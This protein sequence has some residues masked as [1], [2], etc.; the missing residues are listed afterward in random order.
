MI[1]PEP[2]LLRKYV[3]LVFYQRA[4]DSNQ[5]WEVQK[6]KRYFKAKPTFNI[7]CNTKHGYIT[8]CVGTFHHLKNY[9][10]QSFLLPFL[11]L[12][13][14]WAL[15]LLLLSSSYL[16]LRFSFCF[17]FCSGEFRPRRKIY[18]DISGRT[19][20]RFL[21]LNEKIFCDSCDATA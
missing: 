4:G 13:S 6:R 19:F 18:F 7:S 2:Q 17:F 5:G 12:L 14:L 10:C 9:R 16:R 20:Q 11:L 3:G 21:Q 15:Q 1:A 8:I